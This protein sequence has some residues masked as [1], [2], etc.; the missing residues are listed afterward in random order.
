MCSKYFLDKH[1]NIVFGQL[2][3]TTL[4]ILFTNSSWAET[5]HKWIRLYLSS[6][7]ISFQ[8]EREK[9]MEKYTTRI[10]A[11]HTVQT[12]WYECHC[13]TLYCVVRERTHN[14]F[15]PQSTQWHSPMK[16]NQTEISKI[17]HKWE[18]KSIAGRVAV[19]KIFPMSPKYSTPLSLYPCGTFELGQM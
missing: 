18:I 13:I 7:A 8:F 5:S 6:D 10:D 3:P 1:N 11:F 9:M 15:H 14:L 17:R 12:T 16:L 2:F 19:S 4:T